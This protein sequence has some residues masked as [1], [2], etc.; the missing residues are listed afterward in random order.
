MN[1]FLIFFFVIQ[2]HYMGLGQS[3]IKYD[4]WCVWVIYQYCVYWYN[5]FGCFVYWRGERAHRPIDAAY[6]AA[7]TD[8]WVRCL[9][10]VHFPPS[11][12]SFFSSWKK[13]LKEKNT[14]NCLFFPAYFY[15]F[16]FCVSAFEFCG[17]HIFSNFAPLVYRWMALR[18]LRGEASHNR[19]RMLA[20]DIYCQCQHSSRIDHASPLSG[21][22][23]HHSFVSG[24]HASE[25]NSCSC[26]SIILLFFF[27]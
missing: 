26:K 10:S 19:T 23:S 8:R 18:P 22:R 27:C 1:F 21:L 3:R 13:N 14:I 17:F 25:K 24:V 6:W 12:E 9:C 15:E 4:N 11:G 5:L 16:A 7:S 20:L 2:L